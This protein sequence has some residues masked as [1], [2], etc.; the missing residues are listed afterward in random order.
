MRKVYIV[1][2]NHQYISMFLNN[3]WQLADR[4]GDADLI[5][6]TGGADVTPDLFG[7]GEHPRTFNSRIRDEYEMEIFDKYAGEKPLAGIC[8][9]GQFLFVMNGGQMYQDVDKHAI[10]GTH[11]YFEVNDPEAGLQGALYICS[12]TSTHHQMMMWEERL[13]DNIIGI[14]NCGTSY[15]QRVDQDGTIID[16]GKGVE[17]EA[18]YFP[19]S[20]SLCFQP[21]PEF[22]TGKMQQY[23]MS[24]VEQR[25][26][27][28]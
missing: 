7:Q 9:G 20:N 3:G 24:L 27:G 13:R 23:Y 14:A 5:Q 6:F 21:H 4:I 16:D 2:P 8:R 18:A 1:E 11:D 28:G 12:V 17:V 25:L 10:G 19:E 15:R 22:Y 26:F